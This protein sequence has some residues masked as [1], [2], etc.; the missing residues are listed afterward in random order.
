MKEKLLCLEYS[1]L[2]PEA[3]PTFFETKIAG[4]A[5]LSKPKNHTN[6]EIHNIRKKVKD[7]IYTEKLAKKQWKTAHKQTEG[8]PVEQ[9]EEIAKMIG[10]YNDERIKLEHLAS[11]SS[12][13]LESD[14]KDAIM[15]AC[16]KDMVKLSAEKKRIM[17]VVRKLKK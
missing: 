7:I 10:D 6:S 1:T 13:K 8:I 16:E 4:V 3:L 12:P 5:K 2:P 14:E 15:Q 17:G 9:L 11:F